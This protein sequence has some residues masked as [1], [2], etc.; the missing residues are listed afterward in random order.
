[1]VKTNENKHN[2]TKS[3]SPL[4]TSRT[5]YKILSV[6]KTKQVLHISIQANFPFFSLKIYFFS[7]QCRNRWFLR[8]PSSPD[9]LWFAKGNGSWDITK[10]PCFWTFRNIYVRAEKQILNTN[11]ESATRQE[12]RPAIDPSGVNQSKDNFIY[13]AS[14]S[15]KLALIW[16]PTQ[17]PCVFKGHWVG[18]S[19][20]LNLEVKLLLAVKIN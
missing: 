9:M 15:P 7:L 2:N 5:K 20:G 18:F 11:Q 17:E 13:S 16:F 14:C 8:F 1:M 10:K 12:R 6:N 4:I 19:K 3:Q